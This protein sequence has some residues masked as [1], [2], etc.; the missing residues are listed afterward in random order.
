[1]AK[2]LITGGAGYVGSALARRLIERNYEITLID[3]YYKPSNLTEVDGVPIKKQDIRDE[4]DLSEYDVV[5]HLAAI[6]GI[7][8]CQEKEKLANEVNVEGTRNLLKR[9]RRNARVI[10]ASSSAVYGEAKSVAI[11]EDHPTEPLGV[12]GHT[13]LLAEKM[14][15]E[16]NNYCVLRFSNIFGHGLGHKRTVA[17]LFIEAALA[18][19]PLTIH[20]DG[21][22]R[23]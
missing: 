6:T 8:E 19:R 12:Y 7:K 2:F 17:D 13:K 1:M 15:V 22:H 11:L 3:N 9:V 16:H 18:K 4:A 14:V 23:S 10:L 21:P 20:G 5:F